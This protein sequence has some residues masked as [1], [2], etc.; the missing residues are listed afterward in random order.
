MPT[1]DVQ[2]AARLDHEIAQTLAAKDRHGAI[3]GVPLPNSTEMDSHSAAFEKRRSRR[4]VHRDLSIVNKRKPRSNLL[5]GRHRS[6]LILVE[7]P[8][9]GESSERDVETAVR[10][11]AD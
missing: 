1:A 8:D 2:I 5:G 3:D 11:L 10:P 4:R 6:V 9:V 7:L